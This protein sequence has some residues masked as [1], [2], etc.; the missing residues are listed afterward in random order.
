[1]VWVVVNEGDTGN[2]RGQGPCYFVSLTNSSAYGNDGNNGNVEL[3]LEGVTREIEMPMIYYT[4]YLPSKLLKAVPVLD[5]IGFYSFALNPLDPE[6]SG[7]CNFSK[8]YNKNMK[9]VFGNN[10]SANALSQKDLYIYAVNYNVLT[11]TNGMAVV[12]YA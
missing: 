7:T 2:N 4:R 5:R 3:F 8:L 1:M 6:P 12:R 10:Q 11:I 9:M